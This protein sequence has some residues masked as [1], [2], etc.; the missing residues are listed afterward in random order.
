MNFEL[1]SHFEKGYKKLPKKIQNKV[2]ER[3]EVFEND[4]FDSILKNHK[5]HG[6]YDGFR[7]INITS[8]IRIVYRKISNNHYLLHQIGTHSE[9]YS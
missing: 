1:S 7:S 3:L 5:L 2:G 8:D 9:L 4:E 6:E